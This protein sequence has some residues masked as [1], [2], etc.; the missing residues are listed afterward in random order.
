MSEPGEVL[1]A[2][3]AHGLQ[4]AV[5]Q[6]SAR[7][8]LELTPEVI[9]LAAHH[10][11]QGLLW[12]AIADGAVTGTEATVGQAREA[13]V[14]ALR[15]CLLSEQTAVLALSALGRAGVEARV[16]K[17][18]AI[19]HLDH[20]NAAER[21]F[22]D[23]DLLIRRG[24]YHVALAAL[25]D[26]GFRR[27]K[28]PVRSWWE[29]RFAKAIVLLAPSGGELDL[30]LTITG[31]YF[32]EKID[33]DRLWS[34]S[35]ESFDLAGVEAHGL[36]PEG[37]LLHACCHAVLGGA[38]GLRVRRDVAQ[39]VLIS[40][41][42]WEAAVTH[43]EHDGAEQV[44]AEAARTTWADLRLDPGCGFAR[45][46][47][48]L[49]PDTT[50]QRAIASYNDESRGGWG[51][52]GRGTLAALGPTDQIRFLAGLAAPSQPSRQFRG[53]TWT[54]HLRSGATVIRRRS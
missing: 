21:M 54:Q 34:T 50:Q 41:A 38:S 51:P 12:T 35:S 52:E 16:L 29:Q 7:D 1:R 53:R 33:H 15:T 40:N 47:N 24:D 42:D 37:R 19:A 44:L 9:S 45:W 8:P 23:A 14:E 43:A 6:E 20:E 22:G 28:P 11:V 18:V 48:E 2:C 26:A 25:F 5:E 32:G 39:L 10:K 31:G 30:H 27:S 4:T 17:G 3:V 49:A 36:D 13:T 46:A